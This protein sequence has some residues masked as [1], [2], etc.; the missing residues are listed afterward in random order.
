ML[1][2]EVNVERCLVNV[3]RGLDSHNI[4][5][6]CHIMRIHMNFQCHHLYVLTIGALTAI[7][8]APPLSEPSL[9]SGPLSTFP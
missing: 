6:S 7:Q 5:A 9:P 1:S 4:I 3:G 2:V 8:E